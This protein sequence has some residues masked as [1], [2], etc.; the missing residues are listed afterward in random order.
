[1]GENSRS[2]PN[3]TIQCHRPFCATA[4]VYNELGVI[5]FASEGR[6][7]AMG[8]GGE[9][10]SLQHFRARREDFMEESVRNAITSLL[11]ERESLSFYKVAER[12]QV[13]RSTLYRKQNLRRMVEDARAGRGVGGNALSKCDELARENESLRREVLKL[14]RQLER[15]RRD[16]ALMTAKRQSP[17]VRYCVID[18]STAA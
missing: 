1:M 17:S 10:A 18:L 14:R 13:A 4:T 9:D 2:S 8:C 5:C 15:A 11:A 7:G 12:A 3:S 6:I 16:A